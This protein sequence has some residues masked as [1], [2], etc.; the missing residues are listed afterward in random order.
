MVA[1]SF[2]IASPGTEGIKVLVS[3]T[4]PIIATYEGNSAWFSNS[5]YLMRDG[6]GNPGDDG[7][8]SNDLFIFN[9]HSSTVGST[10]SLG[11]FS[12]GTELIFRLFVQNTGDNFFNG[13]ASRNPDNKTHARVQENWMPNKTLVSFE[14]LFNGPFDYNDLSFS[15]TNTFTN[16]G[17][18]LVPEPTSTLSLLALGTL[19]AASTLKRK[20]K[21]SKSTEKE[22]TKVS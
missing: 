4:S 8:F 10:V 6:L 14:D 15:F 13:P 1:Y 22:T 5:L 17:T 18:M 21:T 16:T 3:N 9:N 7:D 11:S 2:P 20:L 19:G 12:I